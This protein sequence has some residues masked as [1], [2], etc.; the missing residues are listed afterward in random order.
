MGN[1]SRMIKYGRPNT[2][3]ARNILFI[4]DAISIESYLREG[5]SQRCRINDRVGSLR[6][7]VCNGEIV[8]QRFRTKSGKQ[9]L[10][11]RS[12]MQKHTLTNSRGN[13]IRGTTALLRNINGFKL[14][15]S[16]DMSGVPHLCRQDLQVRSCNLRNIDIP[17]CF[18]RQLQRSRAR[19][20]FTGFRNSNE[21]KF[22]Q[23]L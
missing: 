21:S 11:Y 13:A 4:I 12:G 3:N 18:T 22:E 17:K 23:R 10:T 6:G 14:V 16:A 7:Q 1:V 2:T 19:K 9:T 5:F 20:V 15:Q 8:R